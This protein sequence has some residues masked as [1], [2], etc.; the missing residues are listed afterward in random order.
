MDEVEEVKSRL[1]IEDVIGEYVQLKRSG[2]NY[3]GLSPFS[4]ERTPSFV[5][6]PEKQIW[7]DFSSGKGGSVFSFLMEVEGIDFKTALEQLARKAGVEL[8]KSAQSAKSSKTRK[9]HQEIYKLATHFYQSQLISNKPALDYLL[10]KRAFTKQTI[11]DWQLGYS[12]NTGNALHL[13]LTKKGIS[14]TEQKAAGLIGI[15][16]DRA[17]DMFRGRIMIPLADA[18]GNIIGYTARQLIEDS[19]SGK[20]INTS[21]TPLYDKSRHV[22]GLHHAKDAIRKAKYV[23]VAEGNLDVISSWQ[24]GVKN[25]VATAGTAMTSFQLEALKRF[26]GDIRICYDADKAGQNATERSLPLAQKAGINL[27]IISIPEGKDPDD[28]VR[29]DL[30]SWK[31]TI[32]QP[33]YSVDWLMQRYIAT[34]DITSALGKT[35]LTDVV[36]S[37]VRGLKDSVE[38]EHYLKK[39][40]KI[41]DSDPKILA[42]KLLNQPASIV[43]KKPKTNDDTETKTEAPRDEQKILCDHLLAIALV[44]ISLRPNILDLQELVDLDTNQQKLFAFLHEHPDATDIKSYAKDLKNISEYVK[45]LSLIV[46]E[47]YNLGDIQ[48]LREITE[49]LRT[50]LLQSSTKNRI[51]SLTSQLQATVD[52]KTKIEI[53]KQISTL[54]KKK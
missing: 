33:I 4:N 17:Y 35:H 46:E 22:F 9:T 18:N 13:F 47:N 38:Q 48:I 31:R 24:A 8:K 7:H 21:S 50:R 40:A 20:Y 42:E 37:L 16:G 54:L 5:V 26:T 2:R 45:I 32:E 30:E 29:T 19:N 51:N 36:I 39:L 3:K 44:Q 53:L 52:Q 6:S 14:E 27:Q 10:Q 11:L 43:R 15:S 34:S 49:K 28:L 23:I 12:P 25:I 41:I 1:N